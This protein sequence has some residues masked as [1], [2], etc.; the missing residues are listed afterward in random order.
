M[1]ADARSRGHRRGRVAL[2][3][4]ALGTVLLLPGGLR[5]D[6]PPPEHPELTVSEA[7]RQDAALSATVL[8]E[9]AA[10]VAPG[11]PEPIAA[12]LAEIAAESG[13]Q[14][15]ALGGVWIAWPEG[16]PEGV[17]TPSPSPTAD[18]GVTDPAGVL[19]LLDVSWTA[20]REAATSPDATDN[21][22]IT[23][24]ALAV[25]RAGQAARLA[26]ALGVPAPNRAELGTGPAAGLADEP[27][28]EALPEVP[29]ADL[30]VAY[31]SARYGLET[32]AARLP[33]PF[34]GL[35]STRAGQVRAA[36]EE[37]LARGAED[38]RALA[39]PSGDAAAQPDALVMGR[40]AEESLLAL[41]QSALPAADPERRGALVDAATTS[42]A[43]VARLGGDLPP[44]PG[45][46]D[47]ED[48]P[49][50]SGATAPG[51]AE[52]SPAATG[53]APGTG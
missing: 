2:T 38:R 8:A 44:L 16:A 47:P 6:T 21:E 26:D 28:P 10:R 22:V 12:A 23:H 51:T 20:A 3:S 14:V 24:A 27:V 29:D 25:S 7:A 35:L 40:A 18:E 39:Y 42:A 1:P 45:I 11:Q 48:G 50:P 9:A 53:A 37:A 15:E 33:E 46:E 17:A 49:D 34:A 5:L 36:L 30:V 43:L 19:A 4:L 41:V 31:D 32:A 13:A 52:P